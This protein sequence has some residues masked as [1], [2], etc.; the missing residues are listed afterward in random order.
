MNRR[1]L[2]LRANQ[3]QIEADPVECARPYV[4]KGRADVASGHVLTRAQHKAHIDT[5]LE[6]IRTACRTEPRH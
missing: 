3:A 2:A 5:H 1:K 6:A 4:D